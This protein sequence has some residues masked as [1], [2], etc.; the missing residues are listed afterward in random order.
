M[1]E[2]IHIY[3]MEVWINRIRYLLRGSFFVSIGPG[4]CRRFLDCFIR[5]RLR[6][7]IKLGEIVDV[8]KEV[9]IMRDVLRRDIPGGK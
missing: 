4:G 7:E 1:P 8:P 9:G 6:S 2:T 5:M 3:F